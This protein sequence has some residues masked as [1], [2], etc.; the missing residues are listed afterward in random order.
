MILNCIVCEK[1]L[2]T[3]HDQAGGYSSYYMVSGGT[4]EKISCGYGSKFDTDILR[5]TIC[6]DCIE[7]KKVKGLFNDKKTI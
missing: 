1:S 2:E 6:D 5:I 4:T 3:L 7:E